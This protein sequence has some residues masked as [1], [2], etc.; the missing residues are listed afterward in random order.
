VSGR[1]VP[2]GLARLVLTRQASMTLV[3][4]LMF[5][6]FAVSAPHFLERQNVI[7]IARQ[8]SFVTIA[9][10]GMTYLFIVGE[11]DLSVGSVLSLSEVL[12]AW[13]IKEHGLSPWT[14][15]VA[16]LGFGVVV[17]LVNGGVS[18]FFKVPSLV[19]TLGMLS[20]LAGAALVITGEFPIDLSSS[21]SSSLYRIVAGNLGSGVNGVPVEIFWM[22]GI[23]IVGAIVLRMTRFGY[24]VFSTGGNERAARAMGINTTRVKIGAFVVV[25]V[26]TAFVAIVQVSWLRNASPIS[27]T[28]YLFQVMGAVILGGISVTGGEGSVYGAFIGAFILATLLDGLVLIGVNGDYNQVL[29]GGI[30][31]VAGLLD[32]GMRRYGWLAGVRGWI[33]SR[34]PRTAVP[35]EEEIEPVPAVPEGG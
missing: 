6:I 9:A 3:A 29:I 26:L 7:E 2:L 28:N 32:V 22:I 31:V 23:G 35:P 27:G 5:A 24:N 18:A 19:V 14:S 15:A 1:R 20:L 30:I 12:M 21:H 17:G 13:L 25:G 33:R 8:M 4:A 11:F 34:L 10:V 16:V